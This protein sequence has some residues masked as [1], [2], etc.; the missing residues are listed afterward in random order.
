MLNRPTVKINGYTYDDVFWHLVQCTNAGM[1]DVTKY[2]DESIRNG[3]FKLD[4]KS[5]KCL[6]SIHNNK[7]LENTK[8]M[9]MFV[10]DQLRS[11]NIEC[12]D[13]YYVCN[14]SVS[15]SLN[16]FKEIKQLGYKS[17]SSTIDY[18]LRTSYNLNVLDYLVETGHKFSDNIL[19]LWTTIAVWGCVGKIGWLKQHGIYPDYTIWNKIMERGDKEHQNVFIIG[20]KSL[21]DK[22]LLPLPPTE[23]EEL[24]K[25]IYR[26]F[27]RHRFEYYQM[28]E[29]KEVMFSLEDANRLFPHLGGFA[30]PVN[31][32][33][34]DRIIWAI[35]SELDVV[36]ESMFDGLE[37][38]VTKILKESINVNSNGFTKPVTSE[39]I[40]NLMESVRNRFGFFVEDRIFEDLQ[41][42]IV[43]ILQKHIV[44]EN[45]AL[46]GF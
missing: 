22:E 39:T 14:I 20:L 4:S 24:T 35:K 6:S 38:N 25:T 36:K 2:L 16:L 37:T 7:N 21:I 3:H 5:Y 13:P 45:I 19:D 29:P 8:K 18:A 46:F 30:E 17:N 42:K 32:F 11:H 27:M 23:E 43:N 31:E 33:T 28:A 10:L 41:E 9:F 12:E 26:F 34:I 1:D 15:V 44:D 40:D